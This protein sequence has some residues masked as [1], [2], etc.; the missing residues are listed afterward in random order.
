MEG[1]GV[2]EGRRVKEVKRGSVEERWQE[3]SRTDAELRKWFMEVPSV[4]PA[5]CFPSVPRC[6]LT[7]A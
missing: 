7:Q 1:G 2:R 6:Q 5:A 4:L 3:V